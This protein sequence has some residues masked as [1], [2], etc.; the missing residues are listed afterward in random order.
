MQFTHK[1][2]LV[3]GIVGRENSI[4]VM[5]EKQVFSNIW[6]FTYWSSASA[7]RLTELF[8]SNL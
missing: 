6:V 7:H 1:T 8:K 2:N 4:V 3:S 5:E